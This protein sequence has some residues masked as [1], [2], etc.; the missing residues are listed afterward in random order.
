MQG[1]SGM[2]QVVVFS[3]HLTSYQSSQKKKRITRREVEFEGGWEM[4]G[5]ESTGLIVEAVGLWE[6]PSQMP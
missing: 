6:G 4:M 3:G 5:P 2:L 1:S